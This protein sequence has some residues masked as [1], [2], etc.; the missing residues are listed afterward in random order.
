MNFEKSGALNAKDTKS[1]PLKTSKEITMEKVEKQQAEDNNLENIADTARNEYAKIFK[2]LKN[3]G[4]PLSEESLYDLGSEFYKRANFKDNKTLGDAI[5]RLTKATGFYDHGFFE[6]IEKKVLSEIKETEAST[7]N[8]KNKSEEIK[9]TVIEG[10]ISI[11]DEKKKEIHERVMKEEEERRKKSEEKVKEDLKK[12][13]EIRE[14]FNGKSEIKESQTDI[15]SD[16]LKEYNSMNENEKRLFSMV[17]KHENQIGIANIIRNEC[18]ISEEEY[19]KKIGDIFNEALPVMNS[20]HGKVENKRWNEI[21]ALS[22]KYVEVRISID[23]A[24]SVSFAKMYSTIRKLSPNEITREKYGFLANEL[25]GKI[26][27]IRKRALDINSLPDDK[28]GVK[29]KIKELLKTDSREPEPDIPPDADILTEKDV[30]ELGINLKEVRPYSIDA[31]EELRRRFGEYPEIGAYGLN[32]EFGQVNGRL[33]WCDGN[34]AI[35]ETPQG[36]IKM[37]F[38]KIVAPSGSTYE[39]IENKWE[40]EKHHRRLLNDTPKARYME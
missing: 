19:D 3:S 38:K 25:I 23:I 27:Q 12:I 31:P 16:I 7:S 1:K 8:E 10:S 5:G 37:P 18:R 21:V 29:N 32:T 22:E 35:F 9:N 14:V 39:Q 6:E 36:K 40:D 11:S 26:D 17:K 24:N 28:L 15:Q 4:D 34:I 30:K 2:E 13:K 33:I 20:L